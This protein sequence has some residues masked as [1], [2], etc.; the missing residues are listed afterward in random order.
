MLDHGATERLKN[1]IISTE[2]SNERNT[3]KIKKDVKEDK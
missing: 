1:G 3:D 2:E